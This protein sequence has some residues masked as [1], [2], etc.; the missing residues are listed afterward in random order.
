MRTSSL[1][2]FILISS[3][4]GFAAQPIILD[5]VKDNIYSL[6]LDKI[7][8][9]EDK[10]KKLN[11]QDILRKSKEFSTPAKQHFNQDGKYIYKY[12]NKAAY[13]IRFYVIN[14]CIVNKHWLIEFLDF[15]MDQI[16][17]YVPD[18][19]GNHSESGN[20]YEQKS[21]FS[22][23]FVR[24]PF[25]HKNF[26]FDIP[27]SKRPMVFY[28]RIEPGN[29]NILSADLKTYK[30]FINHSLTEYY[31]LGIFYGVILLMGMYNLILYINIGERQYLFYV[32]Y[33]LCVGLSSMCHDGTGFQYLWREHPEW[34]G[35]I[36]SISIFGIVIWTIFY[37][38][39][40]LNTRFR[41]PLIDKILTVLQFIA[42]GFFLFVEF[43]SW[44]YTLFLIPMAGI[45][46]L[47][48][49]FTGWKVY[50]EKFKPARYFLMAYTFF[51]LGFLI[52]NLTFFNFLEGNVFTI[53]SYN[54]GVLIEMMLFSIAIGDRIKSMKQEKENALMEK[55]TAQQQ[56]IYQ[57]RENE[58]L[59]DKVNRELEAMVT[60]RTKELNDKNSELEVSNERLK[61]LTD[62]VNQWNVR[63]DLDNR[64]LQNNMKELSQARVLLKDVNFDEF[65]HIFPDENS[66]FRYLAELKWKNGYQCRKCLNSNFGKGKGPFAR[67][68]TKC[69]YDES[70]T[71]DTL[72]HRLRFPITKAFYMVYLVSI[73]DKDI[74]SD[75]LSEI[76][77]LRR[78]TCWSF[79]KK[80]T[81]A[82]K[83]IKKAGKAEAADGWGALALISLH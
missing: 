15:N 17:I 66:C 53:Y 45:P 16:T 19:S 63:L 68:C 35:Q 29:A 32:F 71:N 52:R 82:K 65:S 49:Y 67:R 23:R 9:L 75:E 57:L 14:Q 12:R 60:L 5:D 31:L 4:A 54:L 2:L 18:E 72:F 38:Q 11:F 83:N 40:F 8:I 13:W 42:L 56:T 62:K 70:A 33:V 26:E 41:T 78:E 24:R 74:T 47:L 37:S 80:I 55:E 50:I 79:K 3:T 25:E 69:N 46:F 20:F 28:I 27:S 34:S 1:L 64:K 7:E 43:F 22:Y 77:S 58:R 21:G 81:Q 10:S 6:R 73:K 36:Q 48:I 76:L 30:S 59:K 39:W 61:E 44:D 51:F